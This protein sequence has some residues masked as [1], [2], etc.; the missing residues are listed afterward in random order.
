[1]L[2]EFK[3]NSVEYETPDSIFLPLKNEFGLKVDLAASE[4]IINLKNFIVLKMMLFNMIGLKI[5]G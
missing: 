4:K 5:V 3:S 1:M 2:K